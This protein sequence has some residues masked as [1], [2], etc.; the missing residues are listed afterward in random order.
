MLNTIKVVAVAGC[1]ALAVGCSEDK[2]HMMTTGPD[3]PRSDMGTHY[4]GM[5][6]STGSGAGVQSTV[7]QGNSVNGGVGN[8]TTSTPVG[9][10]GTMGGDTTGH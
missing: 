7:P 6:N 4:N 2:N 5:V 10:G 1:L 8:T 9:G 3:T